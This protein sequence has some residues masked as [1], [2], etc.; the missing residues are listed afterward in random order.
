[1]TGD[2]DTGYNFSDGNSA[3]P[4][5]FHIMPDVPVGG[6]VSIGIWYDPAMF[7]PGGEGYG[8]Y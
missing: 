6:T 4:A 3:A 5:S 2:S 7:D 8:A 1:M